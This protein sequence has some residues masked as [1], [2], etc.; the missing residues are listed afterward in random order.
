[1]RTSNA[2]AL[3]SSAFH[4]ARKSELRYF[5]ELDRKSESS[6]SSPPRTQHLSVPSNPTC[7]SIPKLFDKYHT[8]S[9]LPAPANPLRKYRKHHDS[10]HRH[11]WSLKR[12]KIGLPPHM[13]SNL[14]NNSSQKLISQ[15]YLPFPVVLRP[16]VFKA[17]RGV[18]VGRY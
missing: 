13:K 10:A 1:M 7:L 2:N 4:R 8:S 3:R 17:I 5:C 14:S 11:K 18:C 6:I 12:P 16:P 9:L 15:S